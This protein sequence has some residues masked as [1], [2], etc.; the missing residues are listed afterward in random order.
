M[1]VSWSNPMLWVMATLLIALLPQLMSMP[2]VLVGVT[3]LPIGWRLLAELKG[4]KPLP[5]LLRLAVTVITLVV[6]VSTYGNL[7]GRRAA[8]GL[9]CVMLALKLLETFKARDARIVAS[10]ALFLCATQF[11]FSQG[12]SMV[13]Y[14]AL[15]MV[16]SLVSLAL[17]ERRE[18]FL[19]KGAAPALDR[20]LL[21]EVGF[22]SRL[23]LIAVP[24]GV[25]LFLF[26][27]RWGSPLWGVPER[28][29]D[30][31]T[32]LSDSMTPGSIQAL[33][34]DDSPAFRATF[35]GDPPPQSALYWRGPVLWNFDG[36]TWDMSR[37]STSIEADSMPDAD[38]APYRYQVQLEPNER[39]W[40]FALDYPALKP[41][42]ARRMTFDY[43]LLTRRAITQLTAYEV[44]SDPDFIDSPELKSTFRNM[45]LAL[46]DGF[47]PRTRAMMNEWRAEADT[48]A[49]LVRRAL[50]HFNQEEF[51]YTLNPPLLSGD[52]VD[53]FLFDTRSGFCEHYAS[54]FTVM[55]RMAGIPARVVTGYQ[56]G[57]FNELGNYLLVRQSDAHA[58]AEV[59]LPGTGWTRIDP[60]AA[61]APSR[62]EQGSLDALGGRRHLLDYEWYRGLRNGLDWVNRSWNDW[63]I[64]FD[65]QRQSGL[66]DFMGIEQLSARG[67]VGLLA[68][69]L[70][71]AGLLMTPWLL[72]L[73]RG[74]EQD[75]ALRAWRQF[76]ARLHKAGLPASPSM[77]P[78]EVAELVGGLPSR[79]GRPGPGAGPV[80][81]GAALRL[82]RTGESAVV[83]GPAA[84]QP[85][86]WHSSGAGSE[87]IIQWSFEGTRPGRKT[88]CGNIP[89]DRPGAGRRLNLDL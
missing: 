15:V 53:E 19:P 14:G 88:T 11:L 81:A 4:F 63:I 73:S 54:A 23:L 20:G 75:P 51:R 59:W 28:S 56:G 70:L 8:V 49:A 21:G 83:A 22:G 13:V 82:A 10:L 57:W 61:V 60:T 7:L 46:P 30:S 72:R 39:H 32:G 9:L 78:L 62:V 35:E 66:L 50:A 68:L 76:I 74:R 67:L 58:W 55:M 29:L 1:K 12:M 38:T 16:G 64:A 40:L 85:H 43:Q 5:V 42:A 36:R 71:L 77:G 89:V 47:N 65:A 17:I 87:P 33:F 18:A 31:R 25:A 34:M 41:E 3:L 26:F 37:W 45:A 2:P 6:L 44:A 79:V 27:P 48:D 69:S 24:I 52:S 86:Q 80:L 84:F